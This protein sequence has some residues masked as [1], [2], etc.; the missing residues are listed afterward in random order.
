MSFRLPSELNC[1]SGAG[2]S[3][4]Q[5]SRIVMM[6][7]I[8]NTL[9]VMAPT[10]SELMDYAKCLQCPGLTLGEQIEVA[11]LG[12]INDNVAGGGGGGGGMICGNYG[13]LQPTFVPASGCGGAIDTSNERI[14]W[15]YSG[16][17]H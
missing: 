7:Q 15:Y 5:L 12:L 2:I 11:M 13:G 14:W 8:I 4:G 17:W 6:G 3:P 16:A 9:G 1:I 10:L